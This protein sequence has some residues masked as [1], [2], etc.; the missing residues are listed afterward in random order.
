MA[1]SFREELILRACSAGRPVE[2]SVSGHQEVLRRA[3]NAQFVADACCEVW[4]HDNQP[5]MS[6]A[7]V[8]WPGAQTIV[9]PL[10]THE[11]VEC[12]RCGKKT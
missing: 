7:G 5:L 3:V 8:D 2:E 9:A 1:L 6:G 12:R 4:G 10:R 11:H